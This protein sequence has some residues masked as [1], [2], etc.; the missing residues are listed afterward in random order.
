MFICTYTDDG[1]HVP[2]REVLPVS[3][4]TNLICT[5]RNAMEDGQRHDYI[6]VFDDGGN[7]KGFWRFDADVEYG[8]GECYDQAFLV[9]Q[10]YV[11]ERP[12]A[13]WDFQYALK[14]LKV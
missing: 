11:L 1:W 8:E 10:H 3:S 6:G 9:N 2:S 12:S 7:C 13:A 14:R 5:V 4:L